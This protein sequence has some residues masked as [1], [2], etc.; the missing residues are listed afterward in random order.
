VAAPP[1]SAS[2]FEA[3]AEKFTLAREALNTLS[4]RYLRALR[5]RY[6]GPPAG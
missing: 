6:F 2:V 3:P 1:W 5:A 4:D